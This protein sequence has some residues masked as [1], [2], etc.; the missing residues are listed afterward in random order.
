MKD[1][2]NIEDLIKQMQRDKLEIDVIKEEKN[3]E[4]TKKLEEERTIG[5]GDFTMGDMKVI[6][7]KEDLKEFDYFE[8]PS[9]EDLEIE[10]ILIEEENEKKVHKNENENPIIEFNNIGLKINK[11]IILE[12]VSF[13]IMPGEFVYF[14]GKSG[15]GKSSLS[16]MIYREIK[17]T[18]GT[19]Y[20]DG[21]NITRLKNKNLPKL[22]RKIGVIFQDYKLLNEKTIYENVKYALDVTGYPKKN[23]KEQVLKTLKSVGIIDQKD[24]YPDELSGGQQQRVAIARA[25]V[26]EPIIIV[27]DEPTGNLDPQNA[28]AIMDILK[29]INESGTTIIMATHDVAIVN[30]YKERVILFDKGQVINESIGGYIYE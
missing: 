7:I 22:R 1:V 23:K 21:Q 2:K 30:K 26:S 15:A 10:D 3:P 16:K 27:A 5:F 13:N 20:L 4:I 9:E 8:N 25:I 6:N 12:D 29:K 14:V 24:K 11:T 17:N 28:L 18:T 19:L